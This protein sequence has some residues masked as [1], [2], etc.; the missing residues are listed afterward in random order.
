MRLL[1]W[2]WAWLALV[3]LIAGKMELV[4]GRNYLDLA[5]TDNRLTRLPFFGGGVGHLLRYLNPLSPHPSTERGR[6]SEL[7]SDLDANYVSYRG[8]QL[9]KLNFNATRG[10]SMEEREP[11]E[12]E[13]QVEPEERQVL[14]SPDA[15]F[16]EVV[17][18]FG[19]SKS[20][21]WRAFKKSV[22]PHKRREIV[23]LRRTLGVKQIVLKNL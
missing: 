22:K 1:L 7:R 8:A 18:L 13:E 23:K 16:N 10:S 21:P 19:E 9:W 2:Q 6:I 17:A 14:A 5:R 4:G 11:G 12:E 3:L 15:Q 20:M